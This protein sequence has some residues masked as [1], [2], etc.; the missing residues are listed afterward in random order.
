M[1]NPNNPNPNNRDDNVT[2][3]KTSSYGDGYSDGRAS[4]TNLKS[5]ALE[6]RDHN[7]TAGGF[8][9][10]ISIAAVLGLS[11]LAYYFWGRPPATNSV[12]VVPA[13]ATSQQ[14]AKQTT[15]IEKTNSSKKHRQISHAFCWP[16]ITPTG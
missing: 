15:I 1:T 14:P 5:E 3:E 7:N 8:L 2:K 10:G 9:I 4:G 12:I 11:G 6:V 16:G 13:P